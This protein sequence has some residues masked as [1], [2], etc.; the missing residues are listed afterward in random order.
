VGVSVPWAAPEVLYG[1]SNGD[2][3]SDT[4]SLAATLWHLL[5]GRSPFEVPGGDNSAYALMPRIRSATPPSTGRQDVPAG[6]E[7]L[8]AQA[9][10]KNPTHR[11]ASALEFARALQTVEANQRLARTPIVV[12]DEQGHTTLVSQTQS[13]PA[14]RGDT[15]DDRTRIKAPQTVVA[16][17]MTSA[18][19]EET[20]RRRPEQAPNRYSPAPMPGSGSPPA[21]AWRSPSATASNGTELDGTEFG[22]TELG[23]T[24]SKGTASS[25]AP[26]RPAARTQPTTSQTARLAGE[27]EGETVR[28]PAA[29]GAAAAEPSAP[30]TGAAGLLGRPGVLWGLVASLV[31]LVALVAFLLLRPASPD[32]ALTNPAGPSPSVSLPQLTDSN[33]VPGAVF[34]PPD[35]QADSVK[36]GVRFGWSYPAPSKQDTF[37]L[38][39]GPTASDA[40]KAKPLSLAALNHTVKLAPGTQQCGVVVVVRNGAQSPPSKAVCERAQ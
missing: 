35:L 21:A 20:T 17:P 24:V 18:L 9:M 31:V 7:R 3:R 6:L 16:Q 39:V 15:D 38:F 12:L 29:R 36:G 25:S 14:G 22:G 13:F 10:A 2:E 30:V 4:Y 19:L 40:D 5:V 1:Q 37:Q 32:D 34:D 8:L 33:A 23:G 26:V 28:R 27:A 11:P